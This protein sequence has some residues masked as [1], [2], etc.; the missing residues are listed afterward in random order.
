[1]FLAKA[2]EGQ[3]A[4]KRRFWPDCPALRRHTSL[5]RGSLFLIFLFFWRAG[6]PEEK[7]AAKSPVVLTELC[8]LEAGV[9]GKG[10]ALAG[11]FFVSEVGAGF[12]IKVRVS[13]V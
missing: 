7:K 3:R 1:M 6:L 11:E 12:E 10:D 9:G 4:Q 8:G 13:G 5:G 2:A